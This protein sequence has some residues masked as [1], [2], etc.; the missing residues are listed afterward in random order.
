MEK[1]T[2]TP[3]QIKEKILNINEN[4]GMTDIGFFKCDTDGENL[5]Y[6][7]SIVFPL[8]QEVVSEILKEM[9]PTHSYFHHYRTVNFYLD[10]YMLKLGNFLQ[11]NGYRYVCVGASQSIPTPSSPHGYSGRFSHKKGAT[12]SGL[13]YIGT[14]NLF[15]HKEYGPCVRLGTILT[16][17]PIVEE[18]PPLV[19]NTT[20]INCQMCVSKCPANAIRGEIY[21]VGMEDFKLLDSHAC[22]EYMKK[23]Y[24]LI[25]RGSVCG[26]CMAICAQ[27]FLEK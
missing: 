17:C 9:K 3:Q 1:R 20:C 15:L 23:E 8:S 22:S 16:D 14:N 5:H 24:R 18:N 11:K 10:G 2:L 19:E 4:E 21:T 27:R 6:G 7:I 12:L 25:G 13:G 26:I